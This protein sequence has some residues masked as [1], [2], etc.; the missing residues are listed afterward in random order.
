MDLLKKYV[1]RYRSKIQNVMILILCVTVVMEV[2][3][4]WFINLANGQ[5][6]YQGKK[7]SVAEQIYKED[8]ISP[9]RITKAI[10]E[11]E[12]Y[13]IYEG[14]IYD[15]LLENSKNILQSCAQKGNF[16]DT[17]KNLDLILNNKGVLSFDY[18]Y[19]IEGRM[20]QESLHT[21]KNNFN[22]VNTF[23]K[24]SFII[25]DGLFNIYFIDTEKNEYSYYTLNDVDLV[26]KY[27]EL[28]RNVVSDFSY[29]FNK[30]SNGIVFDNEL[31]ANIDEELTYK[32]I[33]KNNPFT[34]IY[35][36]SPRNLVQSKVEGYFNNIS[37]VK[38]SPSASE[39]AY[40]FSDTDT[41]VKYFNSGILEYS[42]Y[43]VIANS[44]EYSI[45]EDYAIAK[46][47]IAK[48]ADVI[49]K[50]FLKNYYRDNFE[51]VFEFAYVANNYP[52]FYETEAGFTDIPITVTVKNNVVTNYKKIVY[53]F[54]ISES[55]STVEKNLNNALVIFSNK[56]DEPVI[57]NVFL[58]YKTYEDNQ[59]EEIDASL[60]WYLEAYGSKTTLA[61]K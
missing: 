23:N 20:L 21:S 27:I 44:Y 48:D 56:G 25:S 54:E 12:Y 34:T 17:G 7:K 49:N 19:L 41:V 30:G 52:I 61:T 53:N 18:S 16:M 38:F 60:Y 42:Y 40:L 14:L 13:V 29:S 2:S 37:N 50:Y 31:V 24:I 15:K 9:A 45:V 28:S 3:H 8:F 47:F 35:G 36:D 58:G 4:L 22:R 51:T 33:Q 10:G 59:D 11:N 46:G 1:H 32:K 57:D 39:T 55:S 43:N 26:N 6:I 5:S